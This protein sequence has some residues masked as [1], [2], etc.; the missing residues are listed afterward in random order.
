MKTYIIVFCIIASVFAIAVLIYV[1][2]SIVKSISRRAEE[3]RVYRG[4]YRSSLR[5]EGVLLVTGLLCAASGLLLGTAIAKQKN[6]ERAEKCR[7]KR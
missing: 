7:F 6:A 5:T 4:C 2:G 1:I 3:K